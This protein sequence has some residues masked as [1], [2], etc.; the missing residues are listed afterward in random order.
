MSAPE[1]SRQGRSFRLVGGV[2]AGSIAL[3]IVFAA[4]VYATMIRYTPVA[5]QHLPADSTLA[6]RVDLEKVV[7]YEPFRKHLLPLVDEL[8]AGARSSSRLARIQRAT[9]L[10]LGLDLRE[11]AFARG[12]SGSEWVLVAGGKFPKQGVVAG[13]AQVLR[14]DGI[15]TEL[16]PDGRTARLANGIAIGQAEDGA[17]ILASSAERLERALPA[18]QSFRELGLTLEPA[19]S[20]AVHETFAAEL[21]TRA[22]ALGEIGPI[23]RASGSLTLGEPLRGTAEVA[24]APGSDA[25]VAAERARNGVRTL[26]TLLRVA[27]T[28]RAGEARVLETAEITVAGT[29]ALAVTFEWQ[30]E[31]LHRGAQ[32][33]AGAIRRAAGP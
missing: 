8:R 25:A 22:S 10:D 5:A 16:S 15:A 28:D 21:A 19:V 11:I 4:V 33:L 2:F 3:A 29:D 14:E 31:D 12:R 1:T 18:Q 27:G 6:V 20:F 7:L 23:R 30:R 17:L 26:G 9:K 13:V 32:S 24:L